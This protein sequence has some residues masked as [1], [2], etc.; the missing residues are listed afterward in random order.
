MSD[1]FKLVRIQL[2]IIILFTFFKLIRPSILKGDFPEWIK[3]VLLSLPNFFEGIIGVLTLTGF[4]LYINIKV[5]NPYKQIKS[6]I[7][8]IIALIL[9]GIYVLTQEFK[10]HNLGGNNVF[11]KNDVIFSIIGLIIGYLIVL[12]IKPMGLENPEK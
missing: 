11:D 8:Y 6:K 10:I 4:G 7:L 2:V 9:A 3:I 12:I 1:I 5:F